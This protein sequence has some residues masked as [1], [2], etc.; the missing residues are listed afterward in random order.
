MEID[1]VCDHFLRK[2]R[3]I[4]LWAAVFIGGHHRGIGGFLGALPTGVFCEKAFNIAGQ[5]GPIAGNPPQLFKQLVAAGSAAAFA[6]VGTLILCFIVDKILGFR[7][8]RTYETEGLDFG[9]QGWM[10]GDV[11]APAVEIPGSIDIAPMRE[12]SRSAH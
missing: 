2:C 12:R 11:P 3:L 9:E 10:L 1:L 8:S 7:V 4:S 5:D 6:V